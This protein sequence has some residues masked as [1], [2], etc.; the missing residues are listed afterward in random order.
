V[1]TDLRPLL[2]DAPHHSG[3]ATAPDIRTI[4]PPPHPDARPDAL[5]IIPTA[6]GG[7]GHWGALTKANRTGR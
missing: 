5:P 6:Q 2:Q 7:K 3:Q 4:A 1:G